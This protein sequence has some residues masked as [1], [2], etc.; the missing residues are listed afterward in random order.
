[1]TSAEPALAYDPLLLA[2]V[3]VVFGFVANSFLE[4]VKSWLRDR[5]E[6]RRIR[7]N[8]YL[9]VLR[10]WRVVSGSDLKR[11]ESGQYGLVFLTEIPN[12]RIFDLG[13]SALTPSEIECLSEFY[14]KLNV[15]CNY[16]NHYGDILNPDANL[17]NV[18]L[19]Q[20][21]GEQLAEWLPNLQTEAETC[22]DLLKSRL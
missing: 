21:A 13:I 6:V 9:D 22:R 12:A 14:N 19:P 8:V 7:K 15:V 3:A 20:P 18:I 5:H 16:I 17:S 1:M 2:L 10:V 11:S 4:G